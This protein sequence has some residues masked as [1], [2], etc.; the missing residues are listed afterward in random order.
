MLHL[1]DH[2]NSKS[3]V[4]LWV[5]NFWDLTAGFT[6]LLTLSRAFIVGYICITKNNRVS[7]KGVS[8]PTSCYPTHIFIF[9]FHFNRTTLLDV[10]PLCRTHHQTPNAVLIITMHSHPCHAMFPCINAMRCVIACYICHTYDEF[11]MNNLIMH[12][13]CIMDNYIKYAYNL[14]KISF[15]SIYHTRIYQHHNQIIT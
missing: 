9:R 4:F 14:H 10:V 12:F 6:S 3:C 2:L 1:N 11:Y 8:I 15:M 5:A 13:P 7:P